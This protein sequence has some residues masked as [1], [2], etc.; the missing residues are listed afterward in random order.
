LTSSIG[1]LI[2]ILQISGYG[3]FFD[4]ISQ[5]ALNSISGVT[6]GLPAGV[7]ISYTLTTDSK[8]RL[9]QQSASYGG[10][11]SSIVYRYY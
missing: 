6:D 7:T 2:Y 5:K 4:N 9:V 1:P 10:S 8:G 3:G 11:Y